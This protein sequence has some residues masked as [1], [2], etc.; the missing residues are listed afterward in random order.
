MKRTIIALIAAVAT[1][2]YAGDIHLQVHGI[3]DHPNTKGLNERN[4]GLGAR[5]QHTESLSTQVGVYKNSNNETTAYAVG[6]W[7]PLKLG[8]VRA[9]AFAGVAS[10]YHHPE[11]PLVGGLMTTWQGDVVSVTFRTTKSGDKNPAVR[12]LELGFKF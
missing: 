6:Q 7:Q 5:F 9:G 1:T 8:P 2:A 11:A 12:T 4:W 10:R 3:S